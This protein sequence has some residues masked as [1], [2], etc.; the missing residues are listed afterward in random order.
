MAMKCMILNRR[1]SWDDVKDFLFTEW[2]Y[3]YLLFGD[4]NVYVAKK[5]FQTRSSNVQYFT[6]PLKHEQTD[7]W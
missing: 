7:G 4:E 5:A 6:F 3:E 2:W 1:W